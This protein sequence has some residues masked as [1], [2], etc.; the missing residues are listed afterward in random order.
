MRK[1][2]FANNQ[3]YHIFNRGTD[4]RKIFL[5]KSDYERFLLN[6]SILNDSESTPRHLSRF[7]LE[8]PNVIKFKSKPLVE[9]LC[10]CLMPNHY[11]M[12]IRQRTQNGISKF[13]HKLQMGYSKYFNTLYD[14]S[15]NL[16]QGSYKAVPIKKDNQFKYI[17]LYI[18]MNPLDLLENEWKEKGIK[19]LQ[20]GI[21]FVKEYKWSSLRNYINCSTVPYL[22]M[23]IIS[24]LYSPGDWEEEIISFLSS[25]NVRH[26]VSDAVSDISY[27]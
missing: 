19:D 6:S 21:N 1:I 7:D 16:F 27:V 20:K 12:L 10:Y 25:S 4:K 8:N 26:R 22:D 2:F 3:I 9:I 24:D 13:M 15:G 11:H 5:S 14:R 17:P 23:R 18:H